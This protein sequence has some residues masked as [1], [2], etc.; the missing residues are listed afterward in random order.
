MRVELAEAVTGSYFSLLGIEAELG[1]MLVPSDDISPGGHPVI[2]LDH[3]YWQSGFGADPDVIGRD[4]RV[5]GREYTIVG[6]AP[7]DFEG[8]LRGIAPKFYAS[9]MMADE[10][11]GSEV[12]DA[13]GSHS[14]YGNA[15]LRPGVTLPQAEASVASVATSLTQARLDGW[16]PTA[17]FVLVP[18]T[19]VLLYPPMDSYIR[20]SAWLLMVVVGLVLLLACTNLA[21]FLLAR[22]IDARKEIAIRLALG[23][24][25]RALVRR[26]LTETTLVSVAAGGA[27]VALAVWLLDTLVRADLPL[28]IP[29]TLDLGLDWTVLAFT[30][31]VSLVTGV[32]LGLLPAWQSTRPDVAST[33]KSESA[34]GG[35]PRQIRW[36]NML[37]ITQLTLSL[38]LLVGAGLFLRSFQQTLSVD[39]GFGCEPTAIMTFNVPLS[40]F[41][42]DEGRRYTERLVDRFKMLP[43]VESVGLI[44]NLHLNTLTTQSIDFTVDGHEP[45]ADRGSFVADRAGVDPGFFDTAGIQIIR[46]RNFTIGDLPDTQAVAI[47]SDAMAQR[48]WPDGDAVG[49]L[50]R[51]PDEDD[52]DLLVVGVASDAKVRSLGEAPRAL[53]YRPYSQDYA[54][55]LTVLA[56]TTADP[57]QTAIA[58]MMAGRAIDPDLWVWETKTMDRHLGTMVLAAQLAAFV[59]SVFAVLA[60]VLACIGLYGVVSYGVSQRTREV[61][62]RIALGAESSDVVALMA[63]SGLKLVAIGSVVGLAVALL[64]TRLLSGLLF[65]VEAFDLVTF[66]VVPLVLGATALLAA[67]LPALRASRVNAVAALRAE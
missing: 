38:V 34:G 50:V 6:V 30:V 20:A 15:R 3:G 7:A 53:V 1:R 26:L 29:V 35:Q 46:G 33:L 51:Q 18:S 63:A 59:L 52:E 17:Q 21:S 64:V 28:P 25:R 16:D 57:G 43:G 67:Y 14:L 11:F 58:L 62:I 55:A 60:L 45:P 5:G 13:R 36:R 24:T 48:F 42:V 44:D 61:G 12:L 4:L 47:I 65:G 9:I 41:D 10:L 66:V 2:V 37:V 27:G 54:T 39:P 23:A 31:G 49:R 8:S 40:R 56:R 22:A 19:D 32:A